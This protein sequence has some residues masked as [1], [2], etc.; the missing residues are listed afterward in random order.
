MAFALPA[1]AYHASEN[2]F[3]LKYPVGRMAVITLQNKT[4]AGFGND[5]MY[6][7]RVAVRPDA[8]HDVPGFQFTLVYGADSENIALPDTGCH[9]L[10]SCSETQSS[11]TLKNSSGQVSEFGIVV[12]NCFCFHEGPPLRPLHAP[13]FPSAFL[14]H[15][16]EFAL[17]FNPR[18]PIKPVVLHPLSSTSSGVPRNSTISSGFCHVVCIV[19]SNYPNFRFI[20]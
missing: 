18:V 15:P 19:T 1:D 12:V 14:P 9:A 5:T 16:C 13:Q 20:K 10:A 2:V 17:G 3:G 6:K 4:V 8:S 11:A 7:Q